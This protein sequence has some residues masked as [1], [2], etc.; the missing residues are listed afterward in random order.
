MKSHAVIK[1]RLYRHYLFGLMIPPPVWFVL[2]FLVGS[3]QL[4][5]VVDM[6]LFP[7]LY[8][9]VGIFIY[10]TYRV[11]RNPLRRIDAYIHQDG[12][13]TE[14][15]SDIEKK[16]HR[17]LLFLQRAYTFALMLYVTFGPFVVLAR[18]A[19]QMDWITY[20]V[21][22]VTGIPLIFIY[23]SPFI[24]GFFKNLELLS[25]FVPFRKEHRS[26][27]L[28]YKMLMI[29]GQNVVG[30]ILVFLMY[31]YYLNHVY[32]HYENSSVQIMTRMSII[33]LSSLVIV[34]INLLLFANWL[35]VPIVELRDNLEILAG[36]GADL[37][38]RLNINSRDELGEIAYSFNR[39]VESI[40]G[41][42]QSAMQTS[43]LVA[44]SAKNI[45]QLMTGFSE[46]ARMES[47]SL[48]DVKDSMT[49]VASSVQG[50][51][52]MARDQSLKIGALVTHLESWDSI[53]EDMSGKL[54]EVTRLSENAAEKA[55]VGDQTLHET[56]ISIGNI[57]D[58]ADKI[59]DV[60]AIIQDISEKIDLLALNASIEAARAGDSGR[61]F[62]VVAE[63][64]SRLA[65]KTAE[66]INE[67]DTLVHQ[68]SSEV[69]QG[70]HSVARTLT[71]IKEI[72]EDTVKI[73][74]KVQELDRLMKSQI[75]ID[76][77]VQKEAG[78]VSSKAA[79]IETATLDQKK[80]ID[81][82]LETIRTLN[83]ISQRNAEAALRLTTDV[84]ENEEASIYLKES[85]Q[86]FRT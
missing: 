19:G 73:S 58:S 45:S 9:Y 23:S 72:M 22:Y 71:I 47:E 83:S 12:V 11:I 48:D 6:L 77:M 16:A 54:E 76:T 64:I 39:F 42:V 30:V 79:G 70:V 65:V 5:M 15:I 20:V 53:T 34:I 26:M 78:E 27:R 1:G 33:G 75:H 35:S 61:G 85:V 56:S 17:D 67:I 3:F 28:N 46:N 84:R 40:R 59:V 29:L 55:K 52:D 66:S 63:E 69:E 41:V 74:G 51:T 60:V 31:T 21:A 18:V 82:M 13:A 86:I 37:K 57:N 62:A 81:E 80:K 38:A 36:E 14:T 50:V 68:N 25:S 2:N 44:N 24:I 43:N 8:L 7:A 49:H 32:G 4:D 10:G